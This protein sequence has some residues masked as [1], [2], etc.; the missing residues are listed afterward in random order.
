MSCQNVGG[1]VKFKER[2]KWH[3]NGQKAAE[4]FGERGTLHR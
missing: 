3:V 2:E 4:T 1:R